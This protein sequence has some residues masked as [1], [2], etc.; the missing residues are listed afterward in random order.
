MVSQTE[1][2]N[3]ITLKFKFI[4]PTAYGFRN[5]NV[6]ILISFKNRL[7]SMNYKTKAANS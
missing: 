6:R 7:Y 4:E 5:L 1:Q 3:A 2:L